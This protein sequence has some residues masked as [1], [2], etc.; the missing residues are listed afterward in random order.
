MEDKLTKCLTVFRKSQ[1]S[2]LTML[3]KWKREIDNGVYVSA[4]FLDLSMA[5]DTMTMT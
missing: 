2:L 4:L 1:H 5:F 3:Q